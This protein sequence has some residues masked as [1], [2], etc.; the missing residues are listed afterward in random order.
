MPPG[1]ANPPGDDD[2]HWP[3]LARHDLRL[4]HAGLGETRRGRKPTGWLYFFTH[5]PATDAG[6]K[7]GACHGAEIAYVFG[8]EVPEAAEDQQVHEWMRRYWVNF[9]RRGDPNGPGLPVWPRHAFVVVT[10]AP[11]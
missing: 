5:V 6:S 2:L 7:L 3:S 4:E 11:N 1:S 9:A 8:N 10:P